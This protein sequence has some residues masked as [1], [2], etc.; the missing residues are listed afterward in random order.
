MTDPRRLTASLP[1]SESRPETGEDEIDLVGVLRTLWRGKWLIL[2]CTVVA[3][4]LG[5]WYV[6]SLAVPLYTAKAV[7]ALLDQQG[8]VID[9]EG[10]MGGM[11]ADEASIN[12]EA[13][14]MRSRG[15]IERL[16]AD[17]ELMADPEFNWRLTPVEPYWAATVMTALLPSAPAVEP[18]DKEVLDATVDRVLDA[19]RI[20]HL[21]DSYV[22]EIWAE[23]Q[24]AEKS[25]QISNALADLYIT[26]QLTQKFEATERAMDWLSDR[27]VSLKAELEAAEEKL[28]S[29][30]AGSEI[31]VDA[32]TSMAG[33]GSISSTA[34]SGLG[35]QLKDLRDRLSEKRAASAAI[36]ARI[37]AIEAALDEG[38]GPAAI[39]AVAEDPVLER[40]ARRAETGAVP[41]DS[42]DERLS[43]IVERA[44]A[45]LKREGRQ[46]DVLE[47]SIAE[48]EDRIERQGSELV[49]LQQLEREVEASALIYESFLSRLKEVSVQQGI[50]EADA[51]VLS[52]AVLRRKPSAPRKSLVLAL[53][54][55]L[56]LVV[57]SGMVLLREQLQ[58]TFRT[59]DELERFAGRPVLGQIPQVPTARRRKVLQHIASKPASAFSEAVRNLRTS[60]LLSDVDSPPKVIMITSSVPGEGKTTQALSLAQN[61]A[62]LGKKVLLIEADI[63]RRTLSEYFDVAED[64]VGLLA[65][66]AG[67]RP[68]LET[69]FR[70]ENLGMDV[71]L[72]EKSQ[73]NAADFFSSKSF[74]DFLRGARE[75]YEIVILDAP[76]VLAVPDARVLGP[77]A[78]AIIYTVQWDKTART[79]VSEGLRAFQSLDMHVTGLVLSQVNLK[80]MKRYGYA[81]GYGASAEGYYDV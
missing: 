41:R 10:I 43:E 69:T 74:A 23:T 42:F 54:G 22:F 19:I 7:L 63:R 4:A 40:L 32:V 65:A 73:V 2:L 15:L 53:A 70:S 49:T 61:F 12:T 37:E 16:V 13:E 59:S 51:R 57:G 36:S 44:R 30:I 26:D 5:G 67:D 60:I 29:F 80:G 68:L 47:S 28:K 11:S 3:L 79:Q 21:P 64:Q 20:E 31:R 81:S 14:V 52:E 76:P 72:G 6:Y 27:V 35:S 50:Q 75:A 33:D 48:L 58:N 39:A 56:G 66:V 78:D 9:I 62:L 17:L 45:E 8:E 46:V 77:L 1:L 34:L 71:L 25:V 24:S 55:L 18:S 38:V